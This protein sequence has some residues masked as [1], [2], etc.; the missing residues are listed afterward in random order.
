MLLLKSQESPIEN[1]KKS[2]DKIKKKKILKKV[3]KKTRYT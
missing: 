2:N 1:E 3:M